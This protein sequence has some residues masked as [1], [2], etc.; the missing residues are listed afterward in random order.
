M[1]NNTMEQLNRVELIGIVGATRISEA[2]EG[3][4][5][6][7]SL[8]TNYAFQAKDGTAVIETTWHHVVCFEG[9]GVYPLEEIEKGVSLHVTGRLRRRRFTAGNGDERDYVEVMA[10]RVE[11]MPESVREPENE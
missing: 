3:R 6:N 1:K 10:S 4:C 2:G 7:F 5:A 11:K 8:V 9:K